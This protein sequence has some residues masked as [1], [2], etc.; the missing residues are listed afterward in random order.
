[1]KTKKCYLWA[2][3]IAVLCVGVTLQAAPTYSGTLQYYEGIQ[4]TQNWNTSATTF[5]YDVT[6]MGSHWRYSYTFDVGANARAISH[7]II[8]ATQDAPGI[9]PFTSADMDN[10]WTS[11]GIED[12][13]PEI[14]SWPEGHAGNPDIPG[15]IYGIKF[16]LED[17]ATRFEFSFDSRRNPMLGNFYA[18]DG[19]WT[20]Q[21]GTK[22][23]VTAWNTGFLTDRDGISLEDAALNG[24]IVVPNA[25]V[26]PAPGAILLAGIGTLTVGWLRRRQSL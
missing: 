11:W 4:A 14:G 17:G 9:G 26:I 22:H 2:A 19:K 18:K 7:I 5:T 21:D 23:D 10:L 13:S 6:N 1:M 8:E 15:D 20:N 12:G 16:D 24:L 25:T 3:V